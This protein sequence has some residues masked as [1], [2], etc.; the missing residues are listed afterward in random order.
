MKKVVLLAGTF[1]VSLALSSCYRHTVC[2]TYTQNDQ[3]AI[4][5]A[6]DLDKNI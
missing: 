5:K 1:V 2:A 3:P 4:E 6:A